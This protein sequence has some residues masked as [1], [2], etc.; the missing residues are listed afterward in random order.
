MLRL[1]LPAG[2]H[3]V[4]LDRRVHLDFLAGLGIA[5]LTGLVL[6]VRGLRRGRSPG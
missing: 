1:T 2:S 3:T 4:E 6:V 5:L